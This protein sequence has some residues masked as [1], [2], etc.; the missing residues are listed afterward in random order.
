MATVEDLT[1][2]L[3]AYVVNNNLALTT[4]FR[5]VSDEMGV[6]KQRVAMLED[7]LR[8]RGNG[9][10][11]FGG[12]G[13]SLIHPKMLN[14]AVL[15]LPEHWKKWNGDIEEYCEHIHPGMKDVMEQ[16]RSAEDDI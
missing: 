7:L 10:G 3:N 15:P 2:Q 4:S 6:V 8:D 13:R 5:D 12:K 1:A 9:R 16:S 14:P 11:D